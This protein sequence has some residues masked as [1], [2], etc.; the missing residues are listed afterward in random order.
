M[1]KFVMVGLAALVMAGMGG[2]AAADHSIGGGVNYWR[3]IDE[4]KDSPAWDNSGLSYFVA[5]QY[6]PI[7][8]LF[9]EAQLE[10]MPDGFLLS[11]E[12]VYAPQLAVGAKLLFVYGA[13]GVGRYYSDGDWADDPYFTLR[14]GLDLT[15]V[16]MVH[17]DIN[18]SY[19]FYNSSEL[20]DEHSDIDT[21]TVH[22]G[23]AVRVVF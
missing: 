11:P 9:F 21:D 20:G 12:P 5:Y 13:A 7:S 18:A 22:F 23:A 6:K 2:Y 15:L 4:I 17:L 14:A 1:K 10:R 16:P 8:V 3:T 19:I